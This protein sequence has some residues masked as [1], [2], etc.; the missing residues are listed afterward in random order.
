M[1]KT[2]EKSIPLSYSASKSPTE[3]FFFFETTAKNVVYC[4][5]IFRHA[6]AIISRFEIT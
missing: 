5:R 6:L 2:Q 1:R 3:F 4:G